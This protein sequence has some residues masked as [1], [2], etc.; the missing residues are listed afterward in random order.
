MLTDSQQA[1]ATML[2]QIGAVEFGAF[3]LKRHELHPEEP[4]SPIYF[5]LRTRANPKPGPL[6]PEH[7]VMIGQELRALVMHEDLLFDGVGGIPF[8]G[9]PIAIALSVL[10]PPN[11]LTGR[12]PSLAQFTKETRGEHRK[13]AKL[14]PGEWVPGDVLLLVDDLISAGD[15]KRETIDVISA[16]GC[17]VKDLIVLIDRGLEEMHRLDVAVHAVFTLSELLQFYEETGCITTDKAQEVRAYL[18]RP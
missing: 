9:T 12:S 15:T 6:I 7:L 16:A 1:L 4:L 3:R 2:F 17:I 11:R 5:N 8:A 18:A 10:L 13:I 14:N